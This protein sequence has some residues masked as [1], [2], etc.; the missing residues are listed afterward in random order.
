MQIKKICVTI[1]YFL[2]LNFFI[3]ADAYKPFTIM[4]DPA[5]DAQYAGRQIDDSLERGITLQFAE[6]LK[7]IL[8]SRYDGI[9]VVLTRVA[10]ETLQH[11]QNANFA[12]R[13]DVDFYLSIHFYQEKEV[14]PQM[15]LYT[16]SYN[17]D[18]ITR[19]ADLFFYP[20]DQAHLIKKDTTK[21][22]ADKM[23]QVFLQ[24]EYK[25][26]FDL[27]GFFRLPFKPLIAVKA[28]AIGLELGLR[29]KDD[30]VNYVDAFACSIGEIVKL[31][32]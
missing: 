1:T 24:D 15:F 29:Q 28:P 22:W 8:E 25:K 30:W 13:F 10:G 7:Y 17:D 4:L 9:R 26:I 27:Q 6:K 12:N 5:G 19:R 16:F 32:S 23:K 31:N 20:Y 3:F 2:F 11:L 14:K 18:F 21:I